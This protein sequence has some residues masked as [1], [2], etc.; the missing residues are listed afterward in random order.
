[1]CSWF[2]QLT[3]PGWWL[4]TTVF[5]ALN[6]WF[7]LNRLC[8]GPLAAEGEYLQ[9]CVST[10]EAIPASSICLLQSHSQ[11]IGVNLGPPVCWSVLLLQMSR[12]YNSLF[13]GAEWSPSRAT[14]PSHKQCKDSLHSLWP[15]TSSACSQLTFWMFSVDSW[16]NPHTQFDLIKVKKELTTALKKGSKTENKACT[17]RLASCIFITGKSKLKRWLL[18]TAVN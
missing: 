8:P 18:L 15:K 11:K 9:C 6:I 3:D 10:P 13:H 2:C 5:P 1:M 7:G 16:S 14:I 17:T 12:A 4:G